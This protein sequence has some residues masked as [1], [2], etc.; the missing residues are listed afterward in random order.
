MTKDLNDLRVGKG[1]QRTVYPLISPVGRDALEYDVTGKLPNCVVG[2]ARKYP[3]SD[4]GTFLQIEEFVAELDN[5]VAI[6]VHDKSIHT[7]GNLSDQLPADQLH[8]RLERLI[9]SFELA[10]PAHHVLNHAHRV[11][12]ERKMEQILNCV[13]EIRQSVLKGEGLH[14]FLDKVS[15]VVIA[16]K[17]VE[18]CADL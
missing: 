5:V 8:R 14:H 12:V 18:L 11:L 4:A 10:E 7:E 1:L 17:L 15:G 3:L 9:L 16:A 13:V 2:E 6:A